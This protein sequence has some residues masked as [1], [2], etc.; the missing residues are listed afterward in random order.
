[1][2]KKL[3]QH[4]EANLLS[5]LFLGFASGLPFL[6]ILSTLSVW[7]AEI[8]ISK[9]LIG[10]FAW[11]SIPYAIKFLWGAMVDN[12]RLPWLTAR[13]GLRRSWMLLAQCCL[14]LSLIALGMTDPEQNI[15]L[16]AFCALLVGCSSAIQDIVIEAY[17]IESLP[18]NKIGIGAS[19]S[20]LGYRLGMLIAGAGTIYLAAYFDSWHVAYNIIAACMIVGIITTLFAQEP[21][22]SRAPA[23][24]M[25]AKSLRIF[26]R[27]LDWQI[28]IPFILSYKIA[29]TVL[30]IMSMPFLLEIGFNK[31]EIASVAR[32]FGISA[33]I[34]GG[35]VGGV[36]LMWQNLRDNLLICVVL[37]AVASALFMLQVQ[38]G[39]DI[40][41]LFITMGV[42]NFT[43]GMSQVALIA[44]L[45]QLCGNRQT[46]LHYGILS[47][48][49]SIVRV[50]FS[51][52]AGWL[53]DHYAWSQFYGVVCI[54][55]VPSLI[56]LLVYAQHFVK[57][58]VRTVAQTEPAP[59]QA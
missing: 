26:L 42:E 17:R 53:A 49:A 15:W 46:A 48:F 3:A 14:W 24:L 6:M 12:V 37:Q 22:V 10:L 27:K 56:L 11:V 35:F 33:M 4:W 9:T 32:T 54:S 21:Q 39:H 44:Y 30:N 29:D 36:L 25:I 51:A 47:S 31:M 45:S 7:L 40:S 1:M 23:K 34:V 59:A 52:I 16:T 13:L 28:I 43:C 41:F 50:S 2:I 20:V 8:G 18:A 5:V 57:L 58:S 19:A 55:C 38:Y